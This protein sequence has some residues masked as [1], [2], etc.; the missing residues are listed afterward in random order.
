MVDSSAFVVS[1]PVMQHANLMFSVSSLV[2]VTDILGK[3]RLSIGC[4]IN[5]LEMTQARHE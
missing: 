2:A 3:L 5:P 4:N 1:I